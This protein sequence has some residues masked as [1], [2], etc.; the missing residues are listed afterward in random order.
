MSY[1]NVR[2][3]GRLWK[4]YHDVSSGGAVPQVVLLCESCSAK[5]REAVIKRGIKRSTRGTDIDVMGY[6]QPPYTVRS[7]VTMRSRNWK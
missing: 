6:A 2:Q 3:A 7:V 1:G 4:F 5:N